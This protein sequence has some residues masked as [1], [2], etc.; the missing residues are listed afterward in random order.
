MP[1]KRQKKC[2]SAAINVCTLG[3]Y[4]LF[5]KRLQVELKLLWGL[6]RKG[7]RVGNQEPSPGISA[8]LLMLCREEYCNDPV[9]REFCIHR[10]VSAL[11]LTS[12]L[13]TLPFLP[14]YA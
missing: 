12:F 7:T 2:F 5:L 9:Q 4:L 3:I 8:M 14:P 10:L 6:S 13:F 11:R 1:K